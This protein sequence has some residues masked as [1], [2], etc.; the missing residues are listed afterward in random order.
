[1]QFSSKIMTTTAIIGLL[2]ACGGGGSTGS[3]G[4]RPQTV[5]TYQDINS[6]VTGTSDLAAAGWTRVDPSGRVTGT[7]VVSGTLSRPNQT[8]S[9]NGIITSVTQDEI[10]GNWRSGTTT[11]S[12]ST[13]LS[14]NFDF[15]LPVTVTE[16]GGLASQFIVGVVSRTQDFPEAGGGTVGYTGSAR[17]GG[18]LNATSFES[19][20]TL[21]ITADFDN[22]LL[23]LVISELTENG[24]PFETVRIN[25]LA[26]ASSGNA[27]FQNTGTTVFLFENSGGG[28]TPAT[29]PNTSQSASGAFFGGDAGG[30]AEA[31]GA[32][33]FTGDTGDIFGIFAA[34]DRGN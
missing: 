6:R 27:T 10:T 16:D 11:V 3:N 32:F 8:L 26:I 33:S 1:M 14:G 21:N 34:D 24:I 29:G 12:E 28:Y 30:P 9:I 17:V 15:L 22:N 4:D 31:G 2:A 23:D 20:G 25:D 7:E 13:V 19:A 18:I 5:F